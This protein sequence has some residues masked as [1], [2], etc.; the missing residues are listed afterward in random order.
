MMIQSQRIGSVQT[1]APAVCDSMHAHR[2]HHANTG[3]A[4]A[5]T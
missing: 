1:D 2:C 3:A 4:L 5:M